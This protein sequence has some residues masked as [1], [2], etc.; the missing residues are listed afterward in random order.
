M[1][2][3]EYD[4]IIIGAGHKGLTLGAYLQR[5]GLKT[6]IF[7]RRHEEGIAIF[8]SECTAPGFLYNL[9]AQYME[10]LDWMPAWTDFDLPSL[11]ART[12]Y[13]EAQSGIAFSDG[14]P[15]IVLYSRESPEENL[16][17]TR[18]SIAE[19]SKHDADTFIDLFQKVML[20][21]GSNAV[22]LYSPPFQPND[23]APF[24]EQTTSKL[25]PRC[26]ICL[27]I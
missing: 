6:A 20:L 22:S 24:P 2:T 9:H 25:I 13:P 14:R 12:V 27:S 26:E 4:A 17:K 8:T 18:K 5:S 16:E 1:S 7:E 3:E 23:D 19:Y 21:E 11:G 15:S 10:F